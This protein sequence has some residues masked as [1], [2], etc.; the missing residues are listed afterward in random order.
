MD[1][2]SCEV[3]S[4]L[5]FLQFLLETGLTESTLRGYVVAVSDHH[6]GY[7]G[8]SIG[9]QPLVKRFLKGSRRS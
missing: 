5:S 8:Y 1:P 3:D 2:V 6:M 7:G 4:L 9:F